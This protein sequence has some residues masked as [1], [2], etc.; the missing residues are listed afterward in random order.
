MLKQRQRRRDRERSRVEPAAIE[1]A[2]LAS[3]ASSASVEASAAALAT[4]HA[5]NTLS[6]LPREEKTVPTVPP[7]PM[8]AA[9]PPASVASL[10]S[11]AAAL[12]VAAAA[13]RTS[14]F[15]ALNPLPSPLVEPRALPVLPVAPAATDFSCYYSVD[16]YRRSALSALAHTHSHHCA[17]CPGNCRRVRWPR[18]RRC[19]HSFCARRATRNCRC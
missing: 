16:A 1:P 17:P 19:S 8:T 11:A 18:G 7:G 13:R 4:A 15:S 12:A 9:L 5:T 3:S 10:L 6:G 2:V 14:F